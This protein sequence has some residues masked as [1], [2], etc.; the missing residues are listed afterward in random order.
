MNGTPSGE[1]ASL[2]QATD[3]TK[4][5]P[6]TLLLWLLVLSALVNKSLSSASGIVQNPPKPK[7]IAEIRL[8]L[9][10]GSQKSYLTKLAKTLRNNYCQLLPLDLYPVVDVRMCLKG[11][12]LCHFL[13]M[14][15][16]QFVSL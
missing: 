16:L 6:C 14:L 8:L 15:F 7:N 5:N 12:P 10:S 13:C 11:Y 1:V 4:L 9:D 2:A 3:T